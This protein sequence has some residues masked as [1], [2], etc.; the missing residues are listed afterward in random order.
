MKPLKCFAVVLV[1]VGKKLKGNR[2]RE[3]DVLSLID[4][5]HP[6]FAHKADDAVSACQDRT[7]DKIA[8][9]GI[10]GSVAL[11]R[12]LVLVAFAPAAA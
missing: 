7:S 10:A 6:A 2:L 4:L 1:M 12:S 5:A 11:D 8:T 9:P 3:L